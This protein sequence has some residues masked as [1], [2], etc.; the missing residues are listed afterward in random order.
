MIVF[1][2]F[3]LTPYRREKKKKKR[4]LHFIVRKDLTWPLSAIVYDTLVACSPSCVIPSKR[5]TTQASLGS[6]CVCADE[7]FAASILRV[8]GASRSGQSQGF[9][10][11]DGKTTTDLQVLPAGNA[12]IHLSE[13]FCESRSH[14]K[15]KRQVSPS[16]DSPLAG[17]REM[18][19]A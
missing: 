5:N 15:Q 7:F 12:R 10:S 1:E 11:N 4:C 3:Y 6:M 18:S 19:V 13:L 17:D 16:I 8:E 14:L 9:A 2:N